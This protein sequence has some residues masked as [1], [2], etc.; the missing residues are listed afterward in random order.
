[1]LARPRMCSHTAFGLRCSGRNFHGIGFEVGLV[2][3]H[4]SLVLERACGSN[5]NSLPA[6]LDSAVV[7][8]WI[9]KIGR[10]KQGPWDVAEE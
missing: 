7:N 5:R 8:Q 4:T 1:M 6:K 2:P 3:Y 9:F 10:D